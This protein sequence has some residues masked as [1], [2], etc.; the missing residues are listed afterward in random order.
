VRKLSDAALDLGPEP[1]RILSLD[2]GG[3]KGTFSAAVLARL[4]KQLGCRIAEHFDLIV[5]TSTGGILAIGLGLGF[6]AAE[7]LDFYVQRGS[8]IFP[9]T[10]A[11]SR[12]GWLRQIFRPKHSHQI[13]RNELTKI[14]GDRAFCASTCPLVIPTYDAI[15]GRIYLMKTCHAPG[16]VRERDARAVDVALATSAAPTYFQAATFPGHNDASYVDGGVWANSPAMV[17]VTEAIHFFKQRPQNI[18]LLSI[19]ATYSPFNIAHKQKAG[20]AGWNVGLISLMFEAQVQAARAQ[21]GL[22]AGKFHRIDAVVTAGDFVL[23]RADPETIRR[24]AVLGDN[25]GSTKA[26][27]DAVRTHFLN[28][29]MARPYS[30]GC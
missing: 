20:A 29:R 23:D 19:G 3:I 25:E 28:G 10:A 22:I 13:L 14:L 6:S 2:G 12:L 15:G 30:R 26:N 21:A 8:T 5:G 9:S 27:L 24:L 1:F 11:E 7:L 4:E 17:G 18:A 16:L